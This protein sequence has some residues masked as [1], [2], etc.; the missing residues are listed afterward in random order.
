MNK[1][2]PVKDEIIN[3]K[4]ITCILMQKNTDVL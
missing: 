4:S 1:M 2:I 3:K